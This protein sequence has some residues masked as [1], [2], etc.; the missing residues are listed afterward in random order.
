M[1]III[2]FLTKKARKIYL[3]SSTRL[4][5]TV[6]LNP[7]IQQSIKISSQAQSFPFDQFAR[8]TKKSNE[9]V[10]EKELWV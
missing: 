8:A 7:A 2:Y 5:L 10:A 3:R 6:Q 4:Q 9:K 1:T